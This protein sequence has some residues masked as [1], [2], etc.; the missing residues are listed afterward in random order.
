V[1]ESVKYYIQSA[2]R[3]GYNDLEIKQ[4]LLAAGWNAEYTDLSLGQLPG[5]EQAVDEKLTTLREWLKGYYREYASQIATLIG[6]GI[7]GIVLS[8]IEPWALK[9]LLDSVFDSIPAPGPLEQYTGTISLLTIIA[10]MMVGVY[11]GEKLIKL[12]GARLAK[13]YEFEFD[14]ATKTRFFGHMMRLPIKYREKLSGNNY[15]FK[16]ASTASS[17]VTRLVMEIPTALITAALGVLAAFIILFSINWLLAIFTFTILPALFFAARIFGSQLRQADE[18]LE[19]EEEAI[20]QH[21]SESI[22][23]MMIVQ[24]FGKENTQTNKFLEMLDR[25]FHSLVHQLHVNQGFDFI[26]GMIVIIG[27]FTIV[28]V[29]GREIFRNDMTVGE[30][31]IFV[32]YINRFYGPLDVLTKGVNDFKTTLRRVDAFHSLLHERTDVDTQERRGLELTS[33]RQGVIFN[34][35]RLV[36]DDNVI[37]GSANMSVSVGQKIG[38][39]GPTGSGKSTLINT[40]QLF[41]DYDQGS[42]TFDGLELRELNSR[43]LRQQMTILTKDPQLF[44][45]T[46]LNNILY[47]VDRRTKPVGSQDVV[48]AVTAAGALEFIEGLPNNYDTDL[49]SASQFLTPSQRLRIAITRAFLRD[50]PI[51]LIDEP[52]ELLSVQEEKEIMQTIFQ[53]M[54]GK[55]VIMASNK[56][57]LLTQMD[58]VYVLDGGTMLNVKQYGGIDR[59]ESYLQT[60]ELI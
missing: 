23:N 32:F 9:F 30:L 17:D 45:D 14:R 43:T 57:S 19:V 44:S 60:H 37:I 7:L 3:S 6:L 51:L 48:S 20:H 15:F 24:S 8:L 5:T 55:T 50:A 27:L 52:T 13:R 53:L 36:R 41:S 4:S 28:Y 2:R 33:L 46:I 16:Q 49:A 59:Y 22:D 31:F 1:D 10:F 21:V 29:G 11:I 54:Q 38:L 40:M 42:I 56:L 34:G 39:T 25:R 58:E 18:E 26:Q 47:A 12:L 35:A